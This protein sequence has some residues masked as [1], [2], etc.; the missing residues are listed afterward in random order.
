MRCIGLTGSIGNLIDLQTLDLQ[1]NHLSILQTDIFNLINLQELYL[2]NNQLNSFADSHWNLI[3]L[4]TLGL[5]NNQLNIA[6]KEF[7][8]TNWT[9]K[10]LICTKYLIK[11]KIIKILYMFTFYK[12]IFYKKVQFYCW[13]AIVCNGCQ[14]T[15][16]NL[17]NLRQLLLSKNNC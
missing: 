14:Q 11:N 9:F 12:S 4:Q 5:N 16:A 15:M 6:N 17:I 7:N 10:M 1:N 8:W 3:Y 2:H 13:Q